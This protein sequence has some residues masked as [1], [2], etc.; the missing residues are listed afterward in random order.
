[1]QRN[2]A[3]C[4]EWAADNLVDRYLTPTLEHLALVSVSVALGFAI[5]LGLA[6]VS[7]RRRWLTPAITGLTGVLY[8]VP[9]IAFFLLLIPITGRGTDTAIIALTAYTLQIIYR[10][11]VAGLANVPAEARDSG[12][13][14]G[15]TPRQLL[16]RVE[17]PLAVPEIIAGLRIAT[18]STV[19]IATLAVF[20]G[21]GGL[22]AEIYANLTFKTGIIICGAHRDR[23]GDRLRRPAGRRAAPDLALAKGEAGVIAAG[24]SL[25][26]PLASVVDSFSGAIEFIFQQRDAELESEF[27]GTQV[28]GLDQ[29]WDLAWRHIE[30]SALALAV[31]LVLALPIGVVLGHRGKGELLAVAVG[32]AGRAIPELALIAFMV[33]FVG[34]GL[35]NL[36]IALMVLG[37]PPILT[38]AFVGV[39]QVDR[40]A[41]E[42]ARGMGMSAF[43]VVRKVELPLAAPT[44]MTG[45]RTAAINI[46]ATATLGPLVGQLTLGDFIINRNV[47]GDE[48][49]LAGAILVAL[50]ALTVELALAGVQRLLTPRG[51]ALQRAGAGA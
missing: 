43:E 24:L 20:A 31:S 51:L 5:A 42:A 8:T 32:N 14:M 47:Y 7:H 18:V 33:A 28:G 9:S 27:G 41:V 15:M 25:A 39:R 1:M 48:G 13:G 49:V 3:F 6:L 40:G 29:V 12:R 50:L 46:V 11:A 26:P 36:T 35:V 45:V 44:I 16:W 17:L 4:F 34:V 19:A 22:G 23:N 30:V 37:I 21:A 38:N 2:G 10:N